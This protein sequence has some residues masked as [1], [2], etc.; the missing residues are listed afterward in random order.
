MANTK[1]PKRPT[2]IQELSP[3]DVSKVCLGL[4]TVSRGIQERRNEAIHRGEGTRAHEFMALGD[5][6]EALANGVE[7]ARKVLLNVW[8]EGADS[9]DDVVGK[10]EKWEPLAQ[11]LT[12]AL[13]DASDA[14]GLNI[15]H[16]NTLDLDAVKKTIL[17][18][19]T[20]EE[21]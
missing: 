21:E 13:S 15:P 2:E 17:L 11:R 19:L 1:L 14:G 3:R 7:G 6:Y 9:A 16:T 8:K 5:E 10:A 20:K 18:T 12:D 4:R